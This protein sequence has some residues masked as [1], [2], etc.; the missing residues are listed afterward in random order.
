MLAITPFTTMS[1]WLG[2][3]HIISVVAAFGPMLVYPT[4]RRAG[5]VDAL[6]RL[7]MRLTLPALVAL[8]VFGMGLAGVS[9]PSG[10][11]DVVYHVSETWLVLAL[12]DW[13]VL[14]VVAWILIRP[15][16]GDRSDASTARFSAGVG[17]THLGLVVGVV[18][19]I[20][21]PGA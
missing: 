3:L 14:M 6:A 7:H 10:A 11:D 5:A 12:I 2:L 8:W 4:L 9:K 20:W 13:A 1:K 21:K 15:A 17:I 18:L 19:M 16:I